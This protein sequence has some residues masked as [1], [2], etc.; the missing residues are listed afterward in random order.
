M[1]TIMKRSAR[2]AAVLGIAVFG[3]TGLASAAISREEAKNIALEHA[4]VSASEVDYIRVKE[5]WEWGH[6]VY[7]VDFYANYTEYDYDVDKETGNILKSEYETH[8]GRG[9]RGFR[10]HPGQ[11]TYRMSYDEAANLA[12]ARVP[13][14]TDRNLRMKRDHD[15]GIPTYEGKIRYNGY[16]YE[17][18]IDATTG[19]FI[20]WSSESEWY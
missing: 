16:E 1:K 6:A 8:R 5:E 7:D 12:L 9:G 18:E 17:F 11:E 10:G 13:G 3:V 2:L 15:H 20:E 4:G 14:A 19:E